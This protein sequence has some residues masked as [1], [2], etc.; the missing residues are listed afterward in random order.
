MYHKFV[1]EM[2]QNS[3]ICQKKHIEKFHIQ[4]MLTFKQFYKLL[5]YLFAHI[6][7]IQ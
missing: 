2:K 1:G 4:H 3:F 7:Y 5:L 6:N